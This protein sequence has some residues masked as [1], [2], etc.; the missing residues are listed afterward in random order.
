MSPPRVAIS[1]AG[2]IAQIA[3][4][5]GWHGGE[6]PVYVDGKPNPEHVLPCEHTLRLGER[7]AR[8]AR[9]LDYED[10]AEVAVGLPTIK[11]FVHNSTVLWCWVRS[12]ESVKRAAGFTPRPSI[13][14]K[15]GAGA[16]RLLIWGL[17]NPITAEA[18]EAENAR[19]AYALHAPR[20]RIKP[21]ALRVP[22]PGTFARVG[23]GRPAPILVTRLILGE[24]SWE[25]ITA[26]LK[27]PPPTWAE[28]QRA[29]RG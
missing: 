3:F 10:N 7:L 21:D 24:L 29:A 14:L 12:G 18:V 22:L 23:R 15:V 25:S 4:A 11:E 26:D 16:E 8:I 1:P 17:R 19:I 27:S 2:A 13:V 9:K 28:R 5:L 20:T 6:L